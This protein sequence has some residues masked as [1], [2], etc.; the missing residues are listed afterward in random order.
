MYIAPVVVVKLYSREHMISFSYAT[1]SYFGNSSGNKSKMIETLVP[2]L[3]SLGKL[4]KQLNMEEQ[5]TVDLIEKP[6][7]E[8]TVKSPVL[9]C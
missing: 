7:H 4:T 2:T 9:A 5:F 1:C 6:E 8:G 3:T